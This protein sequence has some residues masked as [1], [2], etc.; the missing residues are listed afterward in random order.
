[1]L[2]RFLI[3]LIGCALLSPSYAITDTS[4]IYEEVEGSVYQ[5]RVINDETGKKVSIGSGFVVGENNVLATNYH[6]FQ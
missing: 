6:E 3:L 4:I 1:M 5:I 2:R